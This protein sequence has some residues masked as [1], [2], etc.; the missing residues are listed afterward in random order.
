MR[1]AVA[2]DSG[3]EGVL[4]NDAKC[5]GG[6]GMRQQFVARRPGG[7]SWLTLFRPARPGKATPCRAGR[8][9]GA[10]SCQASCVRPIRYSFAWASYAIR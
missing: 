9:S 4:D 8:R 1:R 7:R 2:R 3:A 10:Q 5:G 6:R